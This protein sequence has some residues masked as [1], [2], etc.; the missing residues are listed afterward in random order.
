[1]A[2]TISVQFADGSSHSYQ[3]VPDSV[4]ADQVIARVRKD[5]SDRSPIHIDRS[6]IKEP[7]TGFLGSIAKG[8]KSLLSSG[9]TALESVT[10]PEEAA[11]AGLKRQEEIS[12]QYG[13]G[14]TLDKLKEIYEKEGLLPA[15][16][17]VVGAIPGAIGEQLPNIA[18][19]AGGA[20]LGAMAGA[21]LGPYGA[22]AGGVLGAVAPSLLQQYGGNIERQAAEEQARGEPVDIDRA[23]ALGLAVP[24]AALDVAAQ[25]IPLGRNLAG[26]LFGKEIEELLLKGEKKAAEKL[27]KE[28]LTKTLIKGT[29]VGALAEIPTEVTQQALERLNAKLSLTDDDALKEYGDTALQVSLLAPIGA[30]GRVSERA[31]AREQVAAQPT[32]EERAPEA[33]ATAAAEQ[34]AETEKL[35][36][37]ASKAIERRINELYQDKEEAD[38]RAARER[39]ARELRFT[40][41]QDERLRTAMEREEQDLANK[42]DEEYLQQFDEQV[43]AREAARRVPPTQQIGLPFGEGEQ[44]QL[45]TEQ[46]EAGV[47]E[48]FMYQPA[49][50]AL[51][52]L[53][54]KSREY[55]E[56]AKDLGLKLN[57]AGEL[58]PYQYVPQIPQ[59]E[60]SPD[61]MRL[62]LRGTPAA[63]L[64]EDERQMA[65]NLPGVPMER[66][67]PA[68]RVL[69]VM[70]IGEIEQPKT[71]ATL[72]SETGLKPSELSGALFTLKDQGVLAYNPSARQ[73]ELTP[74]GAQ[75]V[76]T[77]TETKAPRVRRGV[78]VSVPRAGAESTGPAE[79]T[80]RRMA[81]TGE[82]AERVNAGEVPGAAPLEKFDPVKY[83][84]DYGNKTLD[85]IDKFGKA[86][87]KIWGNLDI[88][89]DRLSI[90]GIKDPEIIVAAENKYFDTVNR[91]PAT[92]PVEQAPAA[93]PVDRM[94]LIRQAQEKRV[95]AN[96]AREFENLWSRAAE[97]FDA[98]KID[99]NTYQKI[100]EELKKPAPNL[101]FINK[102]LL[103]QPTIR[104]AA[105]VKVVDS[106]RE[107][108]TD[109]EIAAYIRRA[110]ER[111]K[112]AGIKETPK[113]RKAKIETEQIEEELRQ[114]K[115]VEPTAVEPVTAEKPEEKVTHPEWATNHEKDVGG[116]IVYSDADTAL[117][118]GHSMLTGQNVYAAIDRKT[119]N[120]TRVDIE[121][122]TGSLFT[123]EQKQR[124]IQAKNQIIARDAEQ[125]AQNP[126]GP[127]TGA[128]SN[129]VASE[130]VNPNY[131]NFLSSLMR[132][133][134]LGDI[135]VFLLHPE[136]I[137]NQQ[138]KY[139]LYGDYAS[140][141]SAGLDSGEDGSLRAYGPNRK[142]FYISFRSGMSEGRSIE[143]IAHELGHLIQR[144]SY[145]NAA[146]E[147]KA[148]IRAEFETWLKENEGKDA[149]QL[150]NALR[151]RETAA[152][153]SETVTANTKLRDSYWRSFSEWFADNTSKWATTSEKPVGIVEKFFAEL[154]K[155]LRALIAK[156]TGNKFV[157]AKSVKEFLDSMGPGSARSWLGAEGVVEK[158]P[159]DDQARASMSPGE[160][161]ANDSQYI[162]EIANSQNT[163]PEPT[164]E[165]K[166]GARTA[167]S[168]VPS[169][170]R[171]GVLSFESPHQMADMYRPYTN[172]LDEIWDLQNRDGAALR[173]RTDKIHDDLKRATKVMSKYAPAQR[174][175]FYDVM[176]KTSVESVEVLDMATD[177]VLKDSPVLKAMNLQW[178]PN[179]ASPLY[180]Q[181]MA[182]PKEVRDIYR[183]LRLAYIGYAHDMEKVMESYL[184]PSEWQKL[185]MEFNK[186]RLP[187]YLPLFRSGDYKLIY[188][189]KDGE[190]NVRQFETDAERQ[191]ARRELVRSGIPNGSIVDRMQNEFSANDIPPAGFYGKVVGAL[192]EKGVSEDAIKQIFD[193]YMDYL[194]SNSV[195]QLRRKRQ[196]TAGYE[197]DVLR[198][199]ASVGSAYARRL[200][201][202]EFMPKL[203]TAYENLQ[204][205]LG[206][207]SFW[208][209]YKDKNGK[210]I[211]NG[212]D[213][214]ELRQAAINTALKD[215]ADRESVKFYGLKDEEARDVVAIAG[216]QLDF[217]NNPQMDNISSKAAYF[218]YTM[219]MGGN[220]SSAVIDLTHIPMVVYSLLGG[221]HGFGRAAASMLRAHSQYVN[222]KFP[223]EISEMPSLLKRA[224]DE[225]VLGE[226]R[227]A[228]LAE[229]RNKLG[230]VGSAALETKARVDHILGY[231]FRVSDKYNRGLTFI[232]AYDLAKKDLQK[233]GVTGD[234]LTN[235]AY[236][237][238]KRAVFDSYGS[239]FP[240]TGPAIA[241]N[242]LAK[243]ALT[244]KRFAINRIWLLSRAFINAAKGESKEV[245]NMARKEL[246]GY[247]GMAYLF[248][249][250]QGMPL[251]GAG[252]LAASL[253]N[254]A[255]G[256]DDEPYDPQ[257]ETLN[258]VGAFN[259]RGPINY[260]FNVDVASR[261]GWDQ[262]LW[263]DDPRRIAEVG[264]ATYAMEQLLGPAFG[265]AVN[266]PRAME[267]FSEGRFSKGMETLTPRVVSNIMKAYRFGTEGALTSDNVPIVKDI[268]K[269]NQ[270]MQILGF[271]P[272]DVSEAYQ[273]AGVASRTQ[274][275]ILER[276]TAILRRMMMA[277]VTQDDK[278]KQEAIEEIQKFNAKHPGK[279]I[280]SDSVRRSVTQ[281]YVKLNQSV[282]GIRVDPKLAREV[283]EQLGYEAG[284]EEED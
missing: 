120:R 254:G 177:P 121:R 123:P 165:I 243:L 131:A 50:D 42:D 157:P 197:L 70:G 246:I 60:V 128:K 24:Q 168:M 221:K 61:Q 18:A 22:I 235:Q 189:D 205:D 101:I 236:N 149:V 53:R 130:N 119:G 89:R 112:A 279:A 48:Q 202:M 161:R 155:K 108:A 182:M 225:G 199:Y 164:P 276:R 31:A 239:S 245:R 85:Q 14:I 28:S 16:K 144:V 125:L 52:G 253:L 11:K 87:Q 41:M 45:L 10:A 86:Y 57:R 127:F 64:S 190:T 9:L 214:A 78:P 115:K 95:A 132:S 173:A 59:A 8:T 255:F 147:T 218:S 93:P 204:A 262:M 208:V 183:D 271:A 283:Y 19:T 201:K 34:P 213:T 12:K 241:G 15:A 80:E 21:P 38:T 97:A 229:F 200:T 104:R 58:K 151:N 270:F 273:V 146:P 51:A 174:D 250:V 228:D 222:N 266:I 141:M 102:A 209:S 140:A 219:Y 162:E 72:L 106:L 192:R 275:E 100:T 148:A 233:K 181:F 49:E 237:E 268:S 153:H 244:F 196:N 282:A 68:D 203:A 126:D 160:Q 178:K 25:A 188:K 281:H 227:L 103:P 134:G 180:A 179:T 88:L 13:E 274:K 117:L 152:A 44:L 150:I 207:G 260:A 247:F 240:R 133:M 118:R 23:R 176:L 73:W 220:V 77:D 136:D 4:T 186:K 166:E 32:V 267:H 129:V 54:P 84:E 110:K 122:F 105:P 252:Q 79:T 195:L 257:Q 138:D 98:G 184:T 36:T 259:F 109:A 226:Q 217:F 33:P 76:R 113:V 82:T 234:A 139:K 26:K 232:S 277:V 223:A 37:D 145:D 156:V 3:N 107:D 171:R 142:N 258:S 163:L 124:L 170:L 111:D 248:S 47:P 75:R 264:P 206:Q 193:L 7:E 251:V 249:G 212:Y 167:M 284:E 43:R 238:A 154:A 231:L 92:S 169:W 114:P 69:R 269:Y 30:L 56:A 159:F 40:A 39:L 90:E 172:Q 63:Q 66:L 185:Q 158:N 116:Q 20:R 27:A 67:A 96:K 224:N 143:T 256:D 280:S 187:V 46:R 194:P 230:P 191:A 74:E 6:D 71:K 55:K 211:R 62:D 5:F 1:M 263:R 210:T 175:R 2:K 278:G 135:K 198:G 35:S 29:A 261:S 94:A 272:S 215:G 81:P 91:K 216:K 137:R 83:A 65:F 242:G 17:E 99:E 265:Y